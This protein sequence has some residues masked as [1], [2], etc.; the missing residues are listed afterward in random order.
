MAALLPALQRCRILAKL[1]LFSGWDLMVDVL[2][3]AQRTKKNHHQTLG[4]SSPRNL[5]RGASHTP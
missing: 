3:D 1:L 4:L 5:T 2:A